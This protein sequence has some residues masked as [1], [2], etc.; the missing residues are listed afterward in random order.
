MA[1]KTKSVTTL[2]AQIALLRRM[3]DEANRAL[4]AHH[5][6][7][8]SSLHPGESCQI[9]VPKGKAEKDCILYRIQEVLDATDSD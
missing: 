1:K 4:V 5:S 8:V 2:T 7:A 3:L 6:T 9:C